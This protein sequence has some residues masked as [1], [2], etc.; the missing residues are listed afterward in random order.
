MALLGWHV[1][2]VLH[3]RAKSQQVESK[4]TKNFPTITWNNTSNSVTQPIILPIFSI[5][6]QSRLDMGNGGCE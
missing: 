1:T 4:G 5:N 6:V 3:Q 2:S